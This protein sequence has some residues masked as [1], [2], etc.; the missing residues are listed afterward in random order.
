MFAENLR[1]TVAAASVGGS[2]RRLQIGQPNPVRS[3]SRY[4]LA[5]T[6]G[7]NGADGNDHFVVRIAVVEF[8]WHQILTGQPIQKRNCRQQVP[9]RLSSH[10]GRWKDLLEDKPRA[11]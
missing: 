3:R 6:V 10:G 1:A 7:A 4:R 8:I 5:R 2:C 9:V 11:E